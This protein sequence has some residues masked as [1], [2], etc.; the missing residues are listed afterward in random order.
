ML[1]KIYFFRF[2]ILAITNFL[3]LAKFF[4]SNEKYE[5]VSIPIY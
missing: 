4:K 5:K 2:T 3:F 1:L